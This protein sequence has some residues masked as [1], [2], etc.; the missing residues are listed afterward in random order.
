MDGRSSNENHGRR[1]SPRR[2]SS[3]CKE[4]GMGQHGSHGGEK[5]FGKDAQMENLGGSRWKERP[6]G[7]LTAWHDRILG[8]GKDGQEAGKKRARG[9]INQE[10]KR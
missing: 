4:T 1:V 8:E 3:V 9:S 2:I 10:K 6:D 7:T 5:N